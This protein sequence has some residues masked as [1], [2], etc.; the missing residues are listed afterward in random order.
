MIKGFSI[1]D[2]ID[3][4]DEEET[5]QSEKKEETFL[6]ENAEAEEKIKEEAE[7][8]EAEKNVPKAAAKK[9]E[10]ASPKEPETKPPQ[11]THFF[12][13]SEDGKKISAKSLPAS[14]GRG[15][16]C[17]IRIDEASI[18]RSHAVI[19][20]EG[21]KFYLED[22]STAGTYLAMLENGLPVIKRLGK[23]LP[24][25]VEIKDGQIIQFAT[26]IFTFNTR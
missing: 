22:T 17:N 19:T 23:D 15:D 16:F 2:I 6:K 13:T 7:I 26:K 21:G 11:K 20:E 12:L 8:K 5:S 25:K 1:N 4:P 9:T 10:K 14:I 24:K 18:S 3:F